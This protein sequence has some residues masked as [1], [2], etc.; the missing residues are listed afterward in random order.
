MLAAVASDR[1]STWTDHCEDEVLGCLGKRT[2]VIQKE[3]LDC[4]GGVVHDLRKCTG[5]FGGIEPIHPKA[6]PYR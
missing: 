3:R 5:S 6:I 1:C 4:S 2:I